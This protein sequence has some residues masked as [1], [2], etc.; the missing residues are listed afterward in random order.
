MTAKEHEE[1]VKVQPTMQPPGFYFRAFNGKRN[2]AP[3]ADLSDWFRIES[4]VLRNGDDVGVVTA[5]PTPESRPRLIRKLF[6]ASSPISTKA[7]RMASGIRTITRQRNARPTMSCRHIAPRYR[8]TNA[9]GLSAAGSAQWGRSTK[10]STMIR[11]AVSHKLALCPEDQGCLVKMGTLS[12]FGVSDKRQKCC[13]NENSRSIRPLPE[14]TNLPNPIP[15]GMGLG[16]V[17]ASWTIGVEMLYYAAFPLVYVIAND[18]WRALAMAI[19]AVIASALFTA[20]FFDLWKIDGSPGAFAPYRDLSIVNYFPTLVL[21]IASY[22]TLKNLSAHRHRESIGHFLTALGIAGLSW[23]MINPYS[24]PVPHYAQ[25]PGLFYALVI[26]GLGLMQWT[27]HVLQ[28]YGRIC[29]SV[30]L[31][32]PRGGHCRRNGKL[33]PDRDSGTAARSPPKEDN[34]TSIATANLNPARMIIRSICRLSYADIAAARERGR[35]AAALRI[36]SMKPG[37][38]RLAALA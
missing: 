5:W 22:W 37:R 19:L 12:A 21:G 10:S 15:F 17:G 8:E 7:W 31:W 13:P 36:P 25:S 32:H 24:F 2:F 26:V 6:N 11:S 4:V 18:A 35:G 28:F 29:Y 1:L 38:S 30:Y 33:L 9:G 23:L 27:N 14:R 16:V 20:L 3:P 34:C